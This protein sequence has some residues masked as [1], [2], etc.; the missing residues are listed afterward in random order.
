M[1]FL[2]KNLEQIIFEADRD[3]LDDRGLYI[4]GKLKR[5][6]SIGN[7]GIADLVG[8]SRDEYPIGEGII[9]ITVYELK[10]DEINIHALLQAVRYVKG[11]KD[12]LL[13]FRNSKL[14]F[15]F[16]I[17]LIGKTINM[18]SFIYIPDVFDNVD[19]YTYEYKVDGIYFKKVEN[20]SLITKG[21]K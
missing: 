18:G 2:E 15:D 14:E 16:D 10:L 13:N 9:R 6:V 19:F 7:Y 20:Y 5:Q 21:F 12:Y 1:D 8:Y 3:K 4:W 11:I 17:T